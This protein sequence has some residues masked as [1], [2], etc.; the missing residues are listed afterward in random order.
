MFRIYIQA[1]HKHTSLKRQTLTRDSHCVLRLHELRLPNMFFCCLRASGFISVSLLMRIG[2]CDSSD[3]F[4][5]AKAYGFTANHKRNNKIWKKKT[6]KCLRL[7]KRIINAKSDIVQTPKKKNIYTKIVN[8]KSMIFIKGVSDV[9]SDLFWGK[10]QI[11][12]SFS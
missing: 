6:W 9:L 8:V 7:P 2:M 1:H 4:Y 11:F 3:L 10:L 5:L 12:I